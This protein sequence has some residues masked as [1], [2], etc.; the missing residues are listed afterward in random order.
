MLDHRFVCVLQPPKEKFERDLG[1]GRKLT[2]DNTQNNSSAFQRGKRG[3]PS[4]SADARDEPDV[5]RQGGG[6]P[7]ISKGLAQDSS[8]AP[9]TSPTGTAGRK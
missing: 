4:D 1:A 6:L 5:T 9:L 7:G 2:A 3:T 8:S